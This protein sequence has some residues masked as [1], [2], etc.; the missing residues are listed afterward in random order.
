MDGVTLPFLFDWRLRVGDQPLHPQQPNELQPTDPGPQIEIP[1]R[2]LVLT[3][4]AESPVQIGYDPVNRDVI[5]A[6][7]P[8]IFLHLI[9]RNRILI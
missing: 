4:G 3:M 2:K 9:C 1:Q 8:I 6:D 5:P 7:H